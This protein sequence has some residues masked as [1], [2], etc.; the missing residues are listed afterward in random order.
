MAIP[1]LHNIDL[2]DNQA[3][4]MRL[5]TGSQSP[6]GTGNNQAY[7]VG[8]GQ[9]WFDS[10]N[11]YIKIHD[12]TQFVK[13]P[14]EITITTGS[15]ENEVSTTLGSFQNLKLI[16]GTNTTFTV[17]TDNAA[18][19]RTLT[20]ASDDTTYGLDVPTIGL[21]APNPGSNEPGQANITLTDSGDNTTSVLI[22]GTD[23]EVD[24]TGDA[25]NETIQIG[26][27]DDVTIDGDLTI[28]GGELFYDVN[29][30][31]K[32]TDP[33]NTAAGKTLTL[34]GGDVIAGGTADLAGGDITIQGGAGKGTGDG[35]DIIFK[36]AKAGQSS[37]STVNALSTALTIS[38]NDG[39]ATFANSVIITGDL[40][41]NGDT[42]SV[43]V[44]TMTVQDPV[45]EL[46]GLENGG[47]LTSNDSKDKGVS[48]NWYQDGSPS[49]VAKLGFFGYD[50]DT[51][52]FTFIPD[53]T[54]TS[55]VF[56]GNKGVADLGGVRVPD[57]GLV[58]NSTAVDSTAAELNKLDAGEAPLAANV[59][60]DDLE[61]GDAIIIGDSSDSNT[62]KKVLLSK[63]ARYV[64][65]AERK[66][67]KI[68][69][70]TGVT[71]YHVEHGFGT[72]LVSVQL[73][74]YGD[75]GTGA[76]YD[77]VYADVT[78]GTVP[79]S[80]GTSTDANDYVN[81]T[82]ATA[83]SATQYYIALVSKF[84]DLP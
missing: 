3:L 80:G 82:F 57:S 54:N 39:D 60:T 19:T 84:P 78:K 35:G 63:I 70:A 17:S 51:G 50:E 16:E 36:I 14:R 4:H 40:T 5:H 52:Y 69:P 33:A 37:G 44:E 62:T 31:I 7:D 71:T 72:H 21:T 18:A 56:S 2:S 29:H 46:G 55:E 74:D 41:V 79:Q 48:F 76:T 30:T 47:A 1:F 20:I 53:A 49:G 42:T 23:K 6:F 67:I 73:L 34:S 43:N 28:K 77:Q 81:V 64:D 8:A 9:I 75:D 15:G 38:G 68:S 45:I 27:P 24:V 10:T 32:S 58:L 26:L 66:S 61:D 22:K 59:F 83:P 11:K 13:A 25:T 12:G 65:Q